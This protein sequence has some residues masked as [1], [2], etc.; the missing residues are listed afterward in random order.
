[1]DRMTNSPTTFLEWLSG[2]HHAVGI[3][4]LFA[5]ILISI[6]AIVCFFWAFVRR[7]E[8]RARQVA[9]EASLKQDM[10]NRGM[11]ADEI[12][13]VLRASVGGATKE[14]STKT[15]LSRLFGLD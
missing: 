15:L 4:I 8:I 14:P 2:P 6:I 12:E 11:S 13:R 5:V 1:M 10:L 9:C 7:A 3:I